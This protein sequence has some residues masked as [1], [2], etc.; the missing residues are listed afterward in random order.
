MK[1]IL[2]YSPGSV[3]LILFSIALMHFGGNQEIY[4]QRFSFNYKRSIGNKVNNWH[5]IKLPADIYKHCNNNLSDLRIVGV[6]PEGETIEAPYLLKSWDGKPEYSNVEFQGINQSR[7]GKTYYYTFIVPS[8]EI[9]NTIQVKFDERNYDRLIMLEGSNDEKI[10]YE[11]LKNYRVLSIQDDQI[12]YSYRTIRFEPARYK[13]IRL[14]FKS[15]F[16][17]GKLK[18]SMARSAVDSGE[19][20]HYKPIDY[21]SIHNEEDNVTEFIVTLPEVLPVSYFQ[22]IIV[23]KNDYYRSY[24]LE[25]AVDS[26][27][28]DETE[29]RYIYRNVS[30]GTISSLDENLIQFDNILTNRIKLSLRNHD[31]VPLI[32]SEA[33]VQ[34]NVNKLIVRFDK[35]AD[36]FLYYGNKD[37]DSPQYDIVAFEHKIPKSLS[38]LSLGNEEILSHNKIIISA[39]KDHIIY[40][41]IALVIVILMMGIATIRMIKNYQKAN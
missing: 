39:N 25:C 6:T 37:L 15:N 33:K 29:W 27:L 34:G 17:P 41:W 30:Y 32:I 23:S 18:I 8:N 24:E 20:Y 12:N 38:N 9:I 10:W 3:I 31:N 28:Y 16:K 2:K 4:A 35:E 40:I 11:F 22:P 7:R 21:E 14:S 5:E 1:N 26:F 13:Y 19:Y 36:Y